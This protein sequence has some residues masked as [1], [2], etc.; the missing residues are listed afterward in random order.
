VAVCRF[1]PFV[2]F[3]IL[4]SLCLFIYCEIII[5]TVKSHCCHLMDCNEVTWLLQKELL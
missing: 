3:N 5:I 1:F 2:L 4:M